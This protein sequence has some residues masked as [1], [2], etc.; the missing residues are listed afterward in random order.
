MSLIF[1]EQVLPLLMGVW[2][3]L[4][5]AGIAAFRITDPKRGNPKL[6][7]ASRASK[8]HKNDC[9]CCVSARQSGTR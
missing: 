7:L 4:L 8:L 5:V 9:T 1:Q 3:K 2:L 6:A